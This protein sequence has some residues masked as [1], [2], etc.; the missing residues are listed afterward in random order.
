LKEQEE[1]TKRYCWDESFAEHRE[2]KTLLQEMEDI[3]FDGDEFDCNF[4]ML[5]ESAQRHV[6]EAEEQMF[7]KVRELLDAAS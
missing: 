5:F 3:G 2:L 4:K 6:Q 7:P 1:L